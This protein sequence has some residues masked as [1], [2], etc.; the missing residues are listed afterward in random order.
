MSQPD[1]ILNATALPHLLSIVIFLP[2]A[3]V[4]A[5]AFS[6]SDLGIRH[7]AFWT[8]ALDF[9]LSLPLYWWFDPAKAARAEPA[10]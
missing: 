5:M 3:G 10:K 6:K 2:L 9:L 8:A 4:A 1:L 7:I